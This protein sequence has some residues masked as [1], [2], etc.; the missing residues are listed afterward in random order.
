MTGVVGA[1]LSG[2]VTETVTELHRLADAVDYAALARLEDAVV[3]APRVF[4]TGAGRSGLMARAVAM[5][6]M[7]IGLRAYAAGEIATPAIERGDLLLAFTG[8][9]S[10]SIG[11]Q[12]DTARA[13]GASVA[14]LTT[15]ADTDLSRQ[16]DIVVTVPARTLVTTVQHAGSLFEQGCLVVGDAL[17][18]AVQQRLAVAT[19]EL[20]RRHANLT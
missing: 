10:R 8:R 4:L 17:C 13:V 2:F 1:D 16:A 19:A 3:Q 7:H 20:D 14:L 5:R 18:R 6:L 9:G 12:V 11:L 15:A